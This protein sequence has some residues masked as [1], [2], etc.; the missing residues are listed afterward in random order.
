MDKSNHVQREH[1]QNPK[2]A[3]ELQNQAIREFV[4]ER[5]QDT[6]TKGPVDERTSRLPDDQNR[7]ITQHN[8]RK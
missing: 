1:N 5:A 3:A 7:L 8:L 4:A 2:E 6:R